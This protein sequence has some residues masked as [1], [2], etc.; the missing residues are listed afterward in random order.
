MTQQYDAIVF[1]KGESIDCF[2][3]TEQEREEK[4]IENKANKLIIMD[5]KRRNQLE[6][7]KNKT[8]IIENPT[9]SPSDPMDPISPACVY[10]S[11]A[12]S[13]GL[14][15]IDRSNGAPVI[16]SYTLSTSSVAVSK[17]EVAS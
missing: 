11:C 9:P 2:I 1:S 5:K 7:M 16:L 10:S 15:E 14:A 12:R 17:C 4:K 6:K 13:S 3:I 8:K